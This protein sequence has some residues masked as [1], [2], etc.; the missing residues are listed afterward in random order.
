MQSSQSS[1]KDDLS[2]GIKGIDHQH[3]EIFARFDY[4][5]EACD[6]S[7]GGKEVLALLEYLD[8]Y[9]VVH[10]AEEEGIL[11]RSGYPELGPHRKQH[12]KFLD[13]LAR[14]RVQIIDDGPAHSGVQAR[15]KGM[16]QWLVDHIVNVDSEYVAHVV[17]SLS[18]DGDQ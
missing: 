3:Q 9:T 1:W 12:R 10:F 16:R 2:C 13:E 15:K 14:L 18:I 7:A 4:F 11:E 17:G 6:D 5:S 8:N